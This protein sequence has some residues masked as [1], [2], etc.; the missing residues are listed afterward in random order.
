LIST[1]DTTFF[2][3]S[4]NKNKYLTLVLTLANWRDQLMYGM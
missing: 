3:L 1:P 4:L 2:L